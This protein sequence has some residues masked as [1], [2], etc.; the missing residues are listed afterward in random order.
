MTES[1][2]SIFAGSAHPNDEEL[3]AFLDSELAP[4]QRE[5]VR[6]HVDTCAVCQAELSSLQQVLVSVQQVRDSNV[7]EERALQSDDNV[8]QFRARLDHHIQEQRPAAADIPLIRKPRAR[9]WT[10]ASLLRYRMPILASVAAFAL[11]VATTLSLRETTASADVLLT[12]SEQRDAALP[13]SSNQVSRSVLNIQVLDANTGQQQSL[14]EYVLLAD[15]RQQQAR[16]QSASQGQFAGEW[17]AN[18]NLF[19]GDLSFKAFGAANYFDQALLHYMQQQNF[20]PDASATQ[21]RKLLEGRGSTE[22]HVRKTKDSYGLDYTFAKNH[23]SGVR[24]AV[25]W[26]NKKSYDPFQMSI[27][28]ANGSS[29]KEYRITRTSHVF[30]Q[31]TPEVTALLSAP[32]HAT[33]PPPSPSASSPSAALPLKYSQIS[34]RPNE[35]RA[36]QLLHQLNACLGEE[37]Y[38][39]PMSDGTALIQGL[40]QNN[41]RR[42]MLLSALTQADSSIH[43]EIYSPEQLNSNVHLLPPPY[44]DSNIALPADKADSAVQS[45]DLSSRQIAFHDELVNSFQSAGESSDQAEKSVASFSTELSSL[46]EK[47]LLNSWAVEHLDTEFTASRTAQLPQSDLATLNSLRQDHRQQIRDIVQRQLALLSR[48]PPPIAVSPGSGIKPSSPRE[49]LDL[50]QEQE[51]LVRALF[52]ASQQNVP[53]SDGF[54]RLVEILRLLKAD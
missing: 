19:W 33:A 44:D 48:I 24:N 11:V 2:D 7:A 39:Y 28:T 17:V 5:T 36:T 46:A 27:Y 14:S 50:A 6:A 38:V 15:S 1:R 13:T 9:P 47:L 10:L 30:E 32:S 26:L 4:G 35:V 21:F 49:L 25:L 43:P 53:K 41:R 51:K 16:L 23:P 42:A 40:V 34:A 54:L 8:E 31:L 45:T 12:R 29:T 52:S 3:M 37:V 22:T 18:G 20:F